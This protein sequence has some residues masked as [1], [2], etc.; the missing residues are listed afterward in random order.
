M[1]FVVFAFN[2]FENT[3]SMI[4]DIYVFVIALEDKIRIS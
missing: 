2:T 4:F 3:R 1:K